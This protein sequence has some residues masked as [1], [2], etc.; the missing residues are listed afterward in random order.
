MYMS[1]S[2]VLADVSNLLNRSLNGTSRTFTVRSGFA[3]LTWP[4]ILSNAS[5]SDVPEAPYA[6]QIVRVPVS[7]GAWVAA[8]VAAS[9]APGVVAPGVV[10]AVVALPPPHAATT[11]A[12]T[13]NSP[14]NRI[15]FFIPVLSPLVRSAVPT[16]G[17]ILRPCVRI[18]LIAPG[19]PP[20]A[21]AAQDRTSR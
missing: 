1:G 13:P 17:T 8:S 19:Q 21:C 5:F 14:A 9:V 18:D 7:E 11:M 4:T 15:G 6:S 20:A 10:G 12:T 2:P 3:V 16:I